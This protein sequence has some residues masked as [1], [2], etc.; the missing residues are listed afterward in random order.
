MR[1]NSVWSGKFAMF[2]LVLGS[3]RSGIRV[4]WRSLKLPFV[5][6]QV[7]AGYQLLTNCFF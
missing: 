4:F 1:E 7:F 6:T 5:A 2:S 3:G